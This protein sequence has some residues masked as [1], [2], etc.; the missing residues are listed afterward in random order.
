MQPDPGTDGGIRPLSADLGRPLTLHLVR[1]ASTALTGRVPSGGDTHGPALSDAGVAEAEALAATLEP[2]DVL[3]SSPLLRTWQTASI[4]GPEP[5]LAP[6]WA[7]LRLG[8][9]DGLPYR[10]IAERWPQEYTRWRESPAARPPGGE[11]VEDLQQRMDAATLRLRTEYPGRTVVVVTHTGPI[12]AVVARALEAG[13]AAFWRLRT[14]PASI[15]TL[16]WWADG[17][18]EVAAV[19]V[20]AV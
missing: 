9:W 14:D 8:E 16:R 3:L 13:P 1:H 4:L 17:G 11:S 5:E 10:E 19:N 2:P 12:R 18:C 7:E 20:R 6:D 15:T